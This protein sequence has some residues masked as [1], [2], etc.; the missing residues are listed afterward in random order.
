MV[1]YD[2]TALNLLPHTDPVVSLVRKRKGET[3]LRTV[4]RIKIHQLG[5][6]S[7][8]IPYTI[9]SCRFTTIPVVLCIPHGSEG[10]V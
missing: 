5:G 8:T 6:Y 7:V 1:L 4:I 3:V 9:Y 2:L 10:V